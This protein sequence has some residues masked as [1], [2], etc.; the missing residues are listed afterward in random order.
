ME[1]PPHLGPWQDD[2][3]RQVFQHPLDGMAQTE[4]DV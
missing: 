4:G 2:E 1:G 3:D